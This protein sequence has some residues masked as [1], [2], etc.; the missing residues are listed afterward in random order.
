[1][2]WISRPPF[3]TTFFFFAQLSCALACTTIT[4]ITADDSLTLDYTVYTQHYTVSASSVNI[5]KNLGGT[6]FYKSVTL[7]STTTPSHD[8]DDLP[9][10]AFAR[11]IISYRK[12]V[13]F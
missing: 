13:I 6:C 5:C 10:A 1:M 2:G 7:D 12:G 9:A 4:I 11:E 3:H 8:D